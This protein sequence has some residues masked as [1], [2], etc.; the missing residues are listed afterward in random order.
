MT[1]FLL[2]L[3]IMHRV[4]NFLLAYSPS[5]IDK[6]NCKHGKKYG[7]MLKLIKTYI[8]VSLSRTETVQHKMVPMMDSG[9]WG[10][11]TSK[12]LHK[13]KIKSIMW[14]I[15]FSKTLGYFTYFIVRII[16]VGKIKLCKKIKQLL[17]II[18]A[19]LLGEAH[20]LAF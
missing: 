20:S 9:K 10:C 6:W 2:L 11:E 15:A 16:N 18:P 5:K 3:L 4:R 12:V 8:P 13:L 7:I 17:Y 14:N 19:I 1:W